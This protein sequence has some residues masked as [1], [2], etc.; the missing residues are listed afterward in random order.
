MED[1]NIALLG[2]VSSA[3][4]YLKKQIKDN[5]E[6]IKE[7][8]EIDLDKIKSELGKRLGSS[9][10]GVQDKSNDLINAGREA[11]TSIKI[12]LY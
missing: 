8:D 12:F 9:F 10:G 11:F 2:F 5:S 6:E 7:L 3:A 4:D 1:K